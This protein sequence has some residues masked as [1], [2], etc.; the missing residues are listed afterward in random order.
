MAVELRPRIV[1]IG[2]GG[3][4]GN[5][6]N[7]MI[8][9]NL[10]GVEFVVANTDAQALVRSKAPTQIQLGIARTSGLGAGANPEVGMEAAKESSDEIKR[11]LNGAHMCFIAAGMG[12]GTGTG[13]APIIARIAK[14]QKVLTVG[15]VTK[16]FDFEGKRRMQVAEKGIIDLRNEVDT[17]L[18]IPNQNLFRIANKD[19]TFADAFGM[20]DKVLY[21]GV[22]GITDLMVMPGLINLDFADVRTVMAGMGSAMMGEGEGEGENRALKAAKAAIANPLLDDVSMKGAKGVLINITGGYDMTLFEVDEAANEVRREVDVDAHIILGSTF[23]EKMVGKIRVSVVAAGLQQIAGVRTIPQPVRELQ[24][25][26][27][28]A[29]MNAPHPAAELGISAQPAAV[30]V[31]PPAPV[32]VAPSVSVAIAQA[33]VPPS[34]LRPPAPIIRSRPAPMPEPE[35][36]DTYAAEVAPAP[37]PQP[38]ADNGKDRSF[39]SLFGWKSKP[40]D[41]PTAPVA[42]PVVDD[43]SFDDDLEIPA[44]LRRSGQA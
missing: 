4:G 7:N 3:A 23:D 44:F 10:Q 18:I 42:K 2:V 41:E 16:P 25:G 30:V 32:A 29:V 9:A 40:A 35:S 11:L 14:E 8:E 34:D 17:L 26:L 38:S 1:V 6:V 5:A 21:S 20:A 39:A 43:E 36:V 13:A 12:G 19:T 33:N 27:T 31:P 24:A 15:V 22:R 28:T 37:A